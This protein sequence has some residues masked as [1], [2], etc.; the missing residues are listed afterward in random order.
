M[1]QRTQTLKTLIE[2]KFEFDFDWINLFLVKHT[3]IL[4]GGAVTMSSL[5][6]IENFNGDLDFYF[7]F[8][9]EE[10]ANIL[11]KKFVSFFGKDFVKSPKKN[12]GE[13]SIGPSQIFKISKIVEYYSNGKKFQL[14]FMDKEIDKIIE[15]FDYT[16][17]QISWNGLEFRELHPEMNAKKEGKY[18]WGD[19]YKGLEFWNESGW[20]QKR[21]QKYIA[22]GFTITGMPKKINYPLKVP[23]FNMKELLTKMCEK[24]YEEVK[25]AIAEN[26][27]KKEKEVELKKDEEL[28]PYKKEIEDLKEIIIGKD[29][30]IEGMTQM[31]KGLTE[32]IEG[33]K[34]K[35]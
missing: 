5:N 3:G 10:K 4:S 25:A 2:T 31:I 35:N 12:Y 17:C 18:L 19:F 30:V 1:D 14:I 24:E 23:E 6:E 11:I 34:L 29:M 16:F 28:R 15:T 20:Q 26:L 27:L 21:Y 7:S 13:Y 32:V 22:R 33:L 9:D 8:V